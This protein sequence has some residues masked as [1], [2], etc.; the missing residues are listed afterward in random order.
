VFEE[1]LKRVPTGLIGAALLAAVA[2]VTVQR[3]VL[4]LP[5]YD[6][7]TGTILPAENLASRDAADVMQSLKQRVGLLEQRLAERAVAEEIDI[8]ALSQRLSH[9]AYAIEFLLKEISVVQL[10]DRAA[11][12]HEEGN[13]RNFEERWA[14][15][16]KRL[17]AAMEAWEEAEA[18]DEARQRY[19][20]TTQEMYERS[21][22]ESL[23]IRLCIEG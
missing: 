9:C 2:V 13:E 14:N 12:N 11:Q 15:M 5:I 10:A 22:D 20:M 4:G 19:N 16:Q 21:G 6:G 18:M 3:F 8:G 17:R 7:T 1:V 23:R